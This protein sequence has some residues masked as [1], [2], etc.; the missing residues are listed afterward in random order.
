MPANASIRL[1][2]IATP[3]EGY[4]IGE[5]VSLANFDDTDVLTWMWILEAKPNG[6]AAALLTS[7]SG[8]TN[9]FVADLEGAYRVSLSVKGS[10]PLRLRDHSEHKR[11]SKRS[12]SRV[13]ESA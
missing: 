2:G 8:S 13:V 6:S 10:V 5:T 9:S 12:G 11:S 7:I 1:D 3:N 4:D